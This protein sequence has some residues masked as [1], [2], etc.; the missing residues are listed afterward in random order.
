[1][2]KVLGEFAISVLSSIKGMV[3][4]TIFEIEWDRLRKKINDLKNEKRGEQ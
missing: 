4:D 2:G 1:M 3:Q